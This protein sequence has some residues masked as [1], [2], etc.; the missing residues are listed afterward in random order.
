M[1]VAGVDGRALPFGLFPH[2]EPP[3]ADDNRFHVGER[4]LTRHQGNGRG[5]DLPLCPRAGLGKAI[6]DIDADTIGLHKNLLH[7]SV[8]FK[9]KGGFPPL[10]GK[11]FRLPIC[12]WSPL[13]YLKGIGGTVRGS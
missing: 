8:D 13:N 12:A 9:E 6:A 7:R 1:G 4:G 2:E 3:A 11:L 5:E 10:R